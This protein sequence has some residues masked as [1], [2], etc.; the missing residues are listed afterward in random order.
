MNKPDARKIY[1]RNMNN[2]QIL[3]QQIIMIILMGIVTTSIGCGDGDTIM[4]VIIIIYQKQQQLQRQFVWMIKKRN[5]KEVT[6]SNRNCL[7]V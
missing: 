3:L 7:Q 5:E 1:S 4:I 6:Q 2:K